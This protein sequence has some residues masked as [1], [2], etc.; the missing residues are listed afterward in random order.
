MKRTV[1]ALATVAAVVA[2][3]AWW[4]P[5][6]APRAA[7][8]NPN[9]TTI[10]AAEAGYRLSIDPVTGEFTD[11]TTPIDAKDLPASLQN[12][13]STSDEGLVERASPVAGVLIDLQGR[14]QSTSVARIDGDGNLEAPCLSNTSEL[15]KFASDV[16]TQA[17]VEKE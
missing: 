6:A 3:A 5:W 4:Q 13:L 12:A 7:D 9:V 2:V 11:E 15:D 10:T 16:E 17:P 14:F 8:T 1:S